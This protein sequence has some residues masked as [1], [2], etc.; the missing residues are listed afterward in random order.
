MSTPRPK[1]VNLA[2]I[3]AHLGLAASTVSRALRGVEGIHPETRAQIAA[4]AQ[5][6][7]Y[8]ASGGSAVEEAES[9]AQVPR[10]V[11]ILSQRTNPQNY[12]NYM[13]GMSGPAS[14]L[15]VAIHFHFVPL[16]QCSS[17]LDERAGPASLRSGLIDGIVL[18][19]RWPAAV[20]ASIGAKFPTASLA[21][22]YPGTNIDL[23]SSD[24]RRGVGDLVD[25]LYAGGH[26]RI[27]FFGLCP[28]VTWSC[29]RYGAYLEALT[30]HGLEVDARL[31]VR[32]DL[33]SALSGSEFRDEVAFNQVKTLLSEGVDAWVCPSAMT[34]Q[35]LCRY[36]LANGVRIPADLS[37]V[38][39]HGNSCP[40]SAD[41]PVIT[42]TEVVD[43]EMGAA[44]LRRLI[45]R[46]E[47][48]GESRQ[49]IL[50]PSK[51]VLGATSRAER[52]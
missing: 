47:A 37:L 49:T 16:D 3:A 32:I 1:R 41:L 8:V 45:N 50:L 43:E 11:M 10:N 5:Q 51:L 2:D 19:S 7:G 17:V 15:N 6:M 30:R 23:I 35:S 29:S 48:P 33:P 46:L 26:R 24:D 28:E 20:A 44:T 4:V 12:Q 52:T 14:A 21:H 25:H 22:D 39:Y 36:L 9:S 13:A 42:T 31:A 34:G 27:G 18:L 38:S 40:S